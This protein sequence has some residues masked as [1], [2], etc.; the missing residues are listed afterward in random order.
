[1]RGGPA[2]VGWSKAAS[3][4]QDPLKGKARERWEQSLIDRADELAVKKIQARAWNQ[5]LLVLFE[6]ARGKADCFPSKDTI[7]KR[8]KANPKTVYHNLRAMSEAGLIALVE[9]GSIK[10]GRRIVFPSHPNAEAVLRQFPRYMHPG[11]DSA[12]DPP[13]CTQVIYRR[14]TEENSGRCTQGIILP[15]ETNS[16]E[17]NDGNEVSSPSPPLRVGSGVGYQSGAESEPESPFAS[18]PIGGSPTRPDGA[19]DDFDFDEGEEEQGN[20]GDFDVSFAPRRRE[21]TVRP[22]TEAEVESGRQWAVEHRRRAKDGTLSEM[23]AWPCP[24]YQP[25]W[26][27]DKLAAIA[28]ARDRPEPQGAG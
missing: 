13:K 28:G 3:I 20:D 24:G 17:T 1:M 18:H 21:P 12:L 8:L 6:S 23:R 22:P 14:C 16:P 9:D 10:V 25:E 7:A 27:P 26:L 4:D 19:A 5:T 15:P 2:S 11:H